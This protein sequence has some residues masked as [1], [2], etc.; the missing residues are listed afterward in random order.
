M[1]DFLIIRLSSLGDIIHTLPAFAALRRARP[2]AGISWAVQGKGREILDLVPGLDRIIEIDPREWKPFSGRFRK[3]RKRLRA[4]TSPKDRT[5]LDF[6]GLIKSAVAARLSGSRRRIGFSKPDLREPQAAL[7]YTRRI[8]PLTEN[9]HVIHKNLKLLEALDIFD[10]D[11]EFPIEIPE[12]HRIAVK[13]RLAGLGFSDA[14]R[15]AL[16]NVGAAWITKRWPDEAWIS[17]ARLLARHGAPPLLLWGTEDERAQAR[18]VSDAAGIPLVPALGLVEVLALIQASRMVVS[19]DTFA[20]QAACALRRPV[21]ALFGPTTPGRNGPFDPADLVIHHELPCS[22]CYRRRCPDK[23]CMERI[24]P[25]E[26]FDQ[27]T[28]RLEADE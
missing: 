13:N 11:W 18:T 23:T 7:F 21:V 14:A 5:A 25:E 10:K 15:P 12:K 4:A 2:D 20:L 8:P 26:V 6:Q 16:L 17:L 28:K 1:S 19:G 24:T 22:H 27:C 9:H 3:D